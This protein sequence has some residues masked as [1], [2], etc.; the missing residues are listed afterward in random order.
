MTTA[1]RIPRIVPE[2]PAPTRRPVRCGFCG[3]QAESP[4]DAWPEWQQVFD[5]SFESPGAD[6]CSRPCRLRAAQ[7]ELATIP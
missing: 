1:R 3:A 7:A 6:Y 2:P 4:A 5:W